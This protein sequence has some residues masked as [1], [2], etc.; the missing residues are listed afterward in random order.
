MKK[1]FTLVVMMSLLGVSQAWA[2]SDYIY[3]SANGQSKKYVVNNHTSADQ[4]ISVVCNLYYSN[5]TEINYDYKFKAEVLGELQ[6]TSN[7]I[8]NTDESLLNGQEPRVSFKGRG[9]AIIVSA[10]QQN[11][12]DQNKGWSTFFVITV[13]YIG[14][15]TWDFFTNPD[16]EM[17]YYYANGFD[18]HWTETTKFS[19]HA[20]RPIKVVD[21]K[22]D[23][24]SN[25]KYNNDGHDNIDGTNARYIPATAGLVFTCPDKGFGV[26]D[27][28]KI[29]PQ[30]NQPY[31]SKRYVTWGKT[32]S[33]LT[34][35]HLKGGTYVRIWW[36][37][38]NAGEFG[39][40]F[41]ADGLLDLDGNYISNQ[42]KITG[43]TDYNVCQGNTIF[44]VAGNSD[45]YYDVSLTLNDDG[46]NDIYKIQVMDK[47]ETDMIL[48]DNNINESI[49][50]LNG[51]QVLYNNEFGTIVHDGSG[52][53]RRYSGHSGVSQIQRAKT[54]EWAVSSEGDVTYTAPVDTWYSGNGNKQVQYDDLKLIITGGTGNIKIIQREKFDGYTLDKNET[55]IAVGTYTQQSYPYTWDFTDYNVKKGS[56]NDGLGHSIEN[57]YGYWE[58]EDNTN[59]V[60]GLDTHALVDASKN[61]TD[62]EPWMN[63]KIEKPL[64]AQGSQL[65]YGVVGNSVEKILE[66]EGLRVKQCDEDDSELGVGDNYDREIRFDITNNGGCL[67]FAPNSRLNHKLYITIPNVTAGMW[68]FIKA[69]KIPNEVKIGAN[70]LSVD[71]KSEGNPDTY[72][73]QNNVWAYQVANTGDVDICYQGEAGV[74]IQ[75]IGVTNIFKSINLLGYATESR[76][77]A[78][79]H[80]Y[81][82]FFTNNDV[83]AFCILT[84]EDGAP[85]EYKGTPIVLKSGEREVNYVPKNTGVV[86]FK[87]GHNKE[88]GGFNVP[89]F[90]PACNVKILQGEKNLFKVNM[91]APWVTEDDHKFETVGRLDAMKKNGDNGIEGFDYGMDVACTKFV[92]SRQYY[93]YNKT[94]NSNSEEKTS[95]QEAFYRMRLSS[96]V[97]GTSNTMGANKAYLLIPTA[98]LPLALWNPQSNGEGIAGQAKPGVIFMDDIM[99]LFGGEEPISGIATAIDTIESAETVDNGNTYY[100]ISGVKIQGRPTEKGV[101][102]MNGK[103]VL[104][105]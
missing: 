42:F 61:N 31:Y 80:K 12:N 84:D 36:D 89:L 76:N 68:V 30:N 63:V 65:T 97:S 105:K 9:G 83:N 57:K 18:N 20:D 93:V 5:G 56:L 91:M 100:T 53:S 35:P 73:T 58:L 10:R 6:L 16:T 92:M 102:I 25:N 74:D 75:A 32:G 13:P 8:I 55:W 40:H 94:Y 15:Q 54:I 79:D 49:N 46:W 14:N 72:D 51:R 95:E 29:N 34:I 52:A 23:T 48:A 17:T 28:S 64:F 98:K 81:E 43:V 50:R 86:L 78:I 60:Y 22:Y 37:C 47:Y 59:L 33:K 104:V 88:K 39:G 90:Y 82:G 69:N 77:H 70:T 45:Q 3:F 4:E 67:R 27:N 71:T 41:L 99:S 21:M 11:N 7:S 103:K 62:N 1:L 2:S 24:A 87:S 44:K 38:I 66:T 26:D 101:Y 19:G 96:G 85:Y